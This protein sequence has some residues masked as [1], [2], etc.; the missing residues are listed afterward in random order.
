M[1]MKTD[2]SPNGNRVSSG[3]KDM[4]TEYRPM[5]QGSVL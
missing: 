2:K 1:G 3:M 5:S 4:K